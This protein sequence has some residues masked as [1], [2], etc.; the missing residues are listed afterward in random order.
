MYKVI[1]CLDCFF[2][3]SIIMAISHCQLDCVWNETQSR[4]GGHTCDPDLEAETHVSLLDLD[5]E[6]SRHSGYEKRHRQGSTHL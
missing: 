3:L 5:T 6:I 2:K 4:L 1:T